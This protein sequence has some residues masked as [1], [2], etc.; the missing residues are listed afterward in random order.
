MSALVEVAESKRQLVSELKTA[1]DRLTIKEQ[2]ALIRHHGS[3]EAFAKNVATSALHDALRDAARIDLA[4][5]VVRTGITSGDRRLVDHPASGKLIRE[6]LAAAKR[7]RV[8]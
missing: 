4:R 8:T 3:R 2:Q 1:F 6:A 7:R 5:A